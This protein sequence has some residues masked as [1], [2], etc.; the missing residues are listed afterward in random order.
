M[1]KKVPEDED[2][3]DDDGYPTDVECKSCGA[4][5]DISNCY[6][7]ECDEEL[8]VDDIASSITH[9]ILGLKTNIIRNESMGCGRYEQKKF[10]RR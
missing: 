5:N 7:T 3:D 1:W 10:E 2:D 8:D 6:C 4:L 9:F